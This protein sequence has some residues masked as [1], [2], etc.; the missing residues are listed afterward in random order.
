M[1][2]RDHFGCPDRSAGSAPQGG[3]KLPD[4]N[5]R[6]VSIVGEPAIELMPRIQF[7]R[8]RLDQQQEG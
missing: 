7:E 6:L 8:D 5:G 4:W 3:V 1:E 2:K